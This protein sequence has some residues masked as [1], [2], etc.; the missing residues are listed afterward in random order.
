MAIYSYV[1]DNDNNNGPVYRFGKDLG[2]VLSLDQDSLIPVVGES[3]GTGDGILT[4]FPLDF[5]LVREGS[6][7]IYF[8]AIEI[9]TGFTVNFI[10]G[11]LLFDSPP[12]VGVVIT[13]DYNYE[14]DITFQYDVTLPM[15]I[16]GSGLS[17]FNRIM[18]DIQTVQG[19]EEF[20]TVD[21][22]TSGAGAGFTYSILVDDI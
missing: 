4:T 2:A 11:A 20:F 13:A 10:G 7:H 8:D 18:S 19:I 9:F 15:T 16:S 17:G 21:A 12:G 6:V 14:G 1:Y 22:T 5:N 3:V